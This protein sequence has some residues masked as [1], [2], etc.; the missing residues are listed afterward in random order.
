MTV[1][2]VCQIAGRT[3]EYCTL[4]FCPAG[5]AHFRFR[6]VPLKLLAP[7]LILGPLTRLVTMATE[8]SKSTA[9]VSTLTMA[10]YQ[11]PGGRDPP[12]NDMASLLVPALAEEKS[13]KLGDGNWPCLRNM[14]AFPVKAV[15]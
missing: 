2:M 11:S 1:G 12:K 13:K 15:A 5:A 10:I 3:L 8:R 4:N 14:S 7:A 6:P 9:F